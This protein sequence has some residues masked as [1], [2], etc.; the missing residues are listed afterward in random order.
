MK[1]NIKKTIPLIIAPQ[2]SKYLGIQVTKHA[3]N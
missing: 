3:Q 2:T 1:A